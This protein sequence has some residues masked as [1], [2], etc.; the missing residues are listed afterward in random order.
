MPRR[1]VTTTTRVT[2]E[3]RVE[4]SAADLRK[5]LRLPEGAE[6]SVRVQI[7][8]RPESV[9]TYN[10]DVVQPLVATWTTTTEPKREGSA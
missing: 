2:R 8:P 3:K 5:R 1:N 6:L 10:L 9:G 7:D 4:F